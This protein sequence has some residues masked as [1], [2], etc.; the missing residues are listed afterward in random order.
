[1]VRDA[2]ANYVVQ[3]TLD[4]VPEG[5]EK[6]LL[7]KE[8]NDHSDQLVSIAKRFIPMKSIFLTQV[9]FFVFS[10]DSTPLRNI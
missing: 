4:V 8:L 9:H 7:L 3:T 1:M 2:Y 5:N 10:S 6:A